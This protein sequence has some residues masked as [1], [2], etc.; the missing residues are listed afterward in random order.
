MT[1]S[2]LMQR[3]VCS[4]CKETKPLSAFGR[5]R[6]NK[7]GLKSQCKACKNSGN[8]EQYK[9]DLEESRNRRREWYWSNREKAIASSSEWQKKNRVKARASRQ[10][11]I[12]TH[13]GKENAYTAGKKLKYPKKIQA[14]TA[15]SNAVQRKKL[16]NPKSL[17]CVRC[18]EDASE[19]HHHN[20]YA[21]KHKLDVVPV[22]RKCHYILDHR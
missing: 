13:P 3:K 11:W 22:C 18:G 21:E 10:R 20:G 2:L 15:V 7:D 12:Q 14:R 19:Y 6:K 16:P 8:R 5:D 9:A 4:T 1:K 17:K